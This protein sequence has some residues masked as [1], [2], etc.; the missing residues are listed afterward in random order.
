MTTLAPTLSSRYFPRTTSWLR[1]LLLI[2][3]GA[4]FVAVMAQVKIPLPFTP[5][6]ITG[7]TF[8]VL[9]VGMGVNGNGI[10][11]CAMTAHF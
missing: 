7:Q 2:T 1:D 8:A 11:T 5:I 4:L 9:L 6:P 10:F 3:L